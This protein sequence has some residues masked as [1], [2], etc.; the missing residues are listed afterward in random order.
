[1][2]DEIRQDVVTQ[3][4]TPM[5]APIDTLRDFKH[6]QAGDENLRA[7]YHPGLTFEYDNYA[8]LA[9]KGGRFECKFRFVATIY[10]SSLLAVREGAAAHLQLLCRPEG[11]KL[12]GLIPA[13]ARLSSMGFETDSGQSF[14]ITLEKATK[15]WAIKGKKHRHWSFAT[16]ARVMFQTWLNPAQ[17]L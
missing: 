13:L 16:E 1:M 10:S 7:D 12:I 2:I 15:S 5:L 11:G 9:Y 6:V 4:F 8:S 17:I 3:I 14:V